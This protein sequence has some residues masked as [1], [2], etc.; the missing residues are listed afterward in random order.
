MT[1]EIC[2]HIRRQVAL[3]EVCEKP[4]EIV[5]AAFLRHGPSARS[6]GFESLQTTVT[7]NGENLKLK[8]LDAVSVGRGL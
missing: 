6:V 8:S 1:F 4:D 5:A 2:V 3:D 7:Q